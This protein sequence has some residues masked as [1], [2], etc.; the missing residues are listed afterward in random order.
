M[1]TCLFNYKSLS[2]FCLDQGLPFRS[3]VIFFALKTEKFKFQNKQIKK[4]KKKLM[5]I[6]IKCLTKSDT[7]NNVL[8]S[9]S[10]G[11]PCKRCKES[12]SLLFSRKEICVLLLFYRGYNFPGSK[13]EKILTLDFYIFLIFYSFFSCS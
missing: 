3:Q 4:K 7:L 12:V 11:Q 9:F 10:V 8:V 5:K 1:I 13:K 2:K 6:K